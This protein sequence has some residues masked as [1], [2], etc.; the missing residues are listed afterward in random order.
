MQPRHRPPQVYEP[1]DDTF[2]LLDVL[3]AERA[4]LRAAARGRNVVELGPG[5]G[6]VSTHAAAWK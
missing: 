5:S 6:V 3:Y 4:A 1:S 2:L